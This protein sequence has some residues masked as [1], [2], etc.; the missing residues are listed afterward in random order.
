MELLEELG[1]GGGF[2]V[3]ELQERNARPSSFRDARTPT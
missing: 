2:Q 3:R 1:V